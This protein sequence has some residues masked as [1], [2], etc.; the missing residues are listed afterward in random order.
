[1]LKGHLSGAL[2]D[3]KIGH[4][5]MVVELQ[6]KARKLHPCVRGDLCYPCPGWA[7]WPHFSWNQPVFLSSGLSFASPVSMAHHCV[8]S[9]TPSNTRSF[10]KA[11]PLSSP[12]LCTHTS[13]LRPVREK[14]TAGSMMSQL[15]GPPHSGPLA[16]PFAF[17][18]WKLLSQ[19][20]CLLPELTSTTLPHSHR[21]LSLISASLWP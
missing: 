2:K 20:H 15:Q 11:L 5:E 12:F 19:N 3:E 9:H 10:D 6:A 8:S 21:A 1:M 18:F 17:P 7:S 16:I 13:H 14:S 4:T